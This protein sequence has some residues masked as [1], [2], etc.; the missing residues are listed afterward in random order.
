[1]QSAISN[2]QEQKTAEAFNKQSAVFDTIYSP[3]IIIQY[4]R[5]RVRD[6]VEKYLPANSNILELNA[7]TGEDAVYFASKG[8]HVHATDIA[9]DM[10]QQLIKKVHDA[11]LSNVSTEICSFNN[12]SKLQ[13]KGPYD[14]IFSNFA[15][16]N[17]TGELDKVLQSFTPLLKQGGI[18]TLVVMPDFCWWETL[19]ALRGNFK[20]AFRRFNSKHG[21]KAN[22][23]GVSF[24]CWYYSPGYITK[25]LKDGFEILSVEG[26]CTIVPPSYFENFPVR[27]PKLFMWLQKVEG[28]LKSLWPWKTT[29]DYFIISLRKK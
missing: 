15:G 18:A 14:L 13:N 26:L 3:N 22:V 20:L 5:K 12:L 25:A 7:G 19:L 24:T 9:A 16:L 2:I 21:V 8:H 6:H 17:C 1:M 28:R 10:Q 29:G 27:F 11:G 4:K 23:E